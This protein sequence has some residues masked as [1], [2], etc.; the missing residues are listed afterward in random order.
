M[1][2]FIKPD[3]QVEKT[4]TG[5]GFISIRDEIWVRP[6]HVISLGLFIE[7]NDTF[8]LRGTLSN[9]KVVQFYSGTKTQCQK[10]ASS[11]INE[12]L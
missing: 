7:D 1:P 3:G 12:L 4:D 5:N 6:E 2:L 11:F 9:S 8:S 10:I